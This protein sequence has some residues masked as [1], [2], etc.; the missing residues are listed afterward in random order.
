MY[1]YSSCLCAFGSPIPTFCS[2]FVILN[3]L[4]LSIY[5]YTYCIETY[6]IQYLLDC[7]L[8]IQDPLLVTSVLDDL[9]DCLSDDLW[10]APELQFLDTSKASLLPSSPLPS[11]PPPLLPSSPPPLLPS[12]PPSLLPSLPPPCLLPSLPPSPSVYT[13]ILYS[14]SFP[15]PLLPSF[16]P[17]PLPSFP[18]PLLP[19]FPPPLLPSS[20]PPLLPSFCVYMYFIFSFLPSSLIF[21]SLTDK[22]VTT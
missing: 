14:P 2:I 22:N 17:S 19:S 15:L 5:I 20:P 10:T 6:I 16:P 3:F 9:R 11:S 21:P 8:Y 13:C 18:P 12:F 1:P 7:L 4:F